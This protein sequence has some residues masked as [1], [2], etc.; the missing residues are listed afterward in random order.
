MPSSQLSLSFTTVLTTV[1]LNWTKVCSANIHGIMLV[2]VCV[3]NVK[4]EPASKLIHSVS[5][6]NAKDDV[7]S[8][9][10]EPGR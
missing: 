9:L 2:S 3:I 8:F 1:D 5:S 7:H 6:R 4:G 10:E